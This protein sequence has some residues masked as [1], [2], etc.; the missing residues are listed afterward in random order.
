[1][2]F[3]LTLLFPQEIRLLLEDL[4]A[5]RRELGVQIEEKRAQLSVIR[6]DIGKE[7]EN[8]QIILGQINKHKIGRYY[9]VQ[10]ENK[11][12]LRFQ[13][14]ICAIIFSAV[15]LNTVNGCRESFPS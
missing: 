4:N 1:M 3:I 14:Y 7:E 9:F 15:S 13:L 5:E 2:T 8:L 12:A 10:T 11:Y 6:K